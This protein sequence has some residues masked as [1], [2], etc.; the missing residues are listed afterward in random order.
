MKIYTSKKIILYFLVIF[1]SLILVGLV[2]AIIKLIN[3]PSILI[4]LII[5]GGLIYWNITLRKIIKPYEIEIKKVQQ[6]V[7][8]C[9]IYWHFLFIVWLVLFGL[10]LLS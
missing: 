2:G 7:E 6:S 8:L 1:I 3:I 10:M 5:I 9:A 4:T